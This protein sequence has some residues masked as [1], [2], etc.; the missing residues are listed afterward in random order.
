MAGSPLRFHN[1][2]ASAISVASA[3][4]MIG[5]LAVSHLSCGAEETAHRESDIHVPQHSFMAGVW[6]DGLLRPAAIA[7]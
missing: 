5:P 2:Y 4:F 6:Q 7:A 3:V 1:M